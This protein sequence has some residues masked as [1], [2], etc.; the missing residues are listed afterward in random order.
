MLLTWI[1][2]SA[3]SCY[4]LCSINIFILNDY[5]DYKGGIIPLTCFPISS[6]ADRK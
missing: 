6:V 1:E 3:H 4:M 5:D 2:L